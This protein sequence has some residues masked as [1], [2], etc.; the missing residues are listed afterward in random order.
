MADCQGRDW[1]PIASAAGYTI[2]SAVLTGVVVDIPNQRWDP[3]PNRFL[4]DA[5]GLLS[6]LAP[7]VVLVL[8]VL[9]LPRRRA[10]ASGPAEAPPP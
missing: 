4:P 7:S 2:V 1:D 9:A 6:L 3:V 8:Q 10:P 5:V